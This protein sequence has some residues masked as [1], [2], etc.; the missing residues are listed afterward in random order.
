[1]KVLTPHGN[2]LSVCVFG[3]SFFWGWPELEKDDLA[4]FINHH[5]LQNLTVLQMIQNAYPSVLMKL[6]CISVLRKSIKYFSVFG[7]RPSVFEACS[8]QTLL[9]LLISLSV[10][11]LG[12]AVL[13]IHRQLAVC[14][15][16]RSHCCCHICSDRGHLGSQRL[17]Q[18]QTSWDDFSEAY[19][20][21]YITA[22]CHDWQKDS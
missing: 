16:F 4:S 14:S 5:Y 7:W 19:L 17:N 11:L 2:Y 18:K 3:S 8:G 6:W 10:L 21:Y 15:A 9:N 13:L 22:I 12:V 20:L 1:M